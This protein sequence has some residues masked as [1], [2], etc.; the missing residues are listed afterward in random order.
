[1]NPSLAVTA[2]KQGSVEI[3]EISLHRRFNDS[4]GWDMTNAGRKRAW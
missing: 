3:Q 1:M 2:T 4:Q